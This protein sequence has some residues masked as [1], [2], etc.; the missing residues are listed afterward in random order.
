MESDKKNV[1]KE[2]D[3]QRASIS[4]KILLISELEH[5]RAHALRS[6]VATYRGGGESDDSEWVKYALVAKQARDIRRDYQKK[7]FP[8]IS[9]Y[10][11]CLV[12]AASH[13]RQLAYEIQEDDYGMLKAID[14]FLDEILGNALNVDLSDC[15]SCRE[16]KDDA[17]VM[18]EA[19][20]Q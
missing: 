8:E 19:G 5:I 17:P 6:A 11:W 13:A 4:D 9:E 15:S 18:I 20:L 14:D 10:D 2:F 1:K 16:D 12:K 7:H 3:H